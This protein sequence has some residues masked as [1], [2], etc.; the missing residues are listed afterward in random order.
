IVEAEQGSPPGSLGYA[1]LQRSVVQSGGKG[2]RKH[3]AELLRINGP[4]GEHRVTRHR[5]IRPVVWVENED[6]INAEGIDQ[7]FCFRNV[8]AAPVVGRVCARAQKWMAMHK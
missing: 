6:R 5:R 2:A 8:G 3:P 4:P 7:Q 1:A